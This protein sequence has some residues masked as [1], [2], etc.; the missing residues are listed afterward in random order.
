MKRAREDEETASA[1]ACTEKGAAILFY[2]EQEVPYGCF[3]NFSRHAVTMG[4]RVF[5][6]SEHY[7]Q[8]MKFAATPKHFDFVASRA[9]PAAAAA[10]GR[11]RKRPLRGDWEQVKDGIMYDVVLAKFLQHDDIQKILLS[12]GDAKLVEHTG[13][14]RYWGDGGDGSGKNMLGQTLVRVRE[15]IRK[16]GVPPVATE[17][18]STTVAPGHNSGTSAD[19]RGANINNGGPGDNGTSPGPSGASSEASGIDN[20]GLPSNGIVQKN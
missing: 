4:G 15:E 16:R 8:A 10:A 18:T 14:D 17:P 1:V 3:S 9:T 13:K 20:D 2:K 19:N 5:K 11:D 12:T 7:F 6:T